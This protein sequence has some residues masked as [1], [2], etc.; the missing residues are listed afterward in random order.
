MVRV[1]FSAMC[2]PSP[3]WAPEGC[4]FRGQRA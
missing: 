1:V 2:A 3:R 4:A